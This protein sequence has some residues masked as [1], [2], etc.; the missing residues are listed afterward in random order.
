M[1]HEIGGDARVPVTVR[2]RV[3]QVAQL[4]M[5]L[6][7]RIVRDDDAIEGGAGRPDPFAAL[8]HRE[9]TAH[10]ELAAE[11]LRRD[12]QQSLH[13]GTIKRPVALCSRPPHRRSLSAIEHSELDSR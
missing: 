9:R 12:P 11:A 10:L 5:V 6:E 4:R 7:Q 1:Q 2:L 13:R 8:H 3:N